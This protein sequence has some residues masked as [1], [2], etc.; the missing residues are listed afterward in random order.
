ML[1]DD[2]ALTIDTALFAARWSHIQSDYLLPNGIVA[3]QN[4]G[5]GDNFGLKATLHWRP[6]GP[7][8]LDGDVLLQHARLTHAKVDVDED[9]R[10]PVVPDVRLR[11]VLGRTFS[12]GAWTGVLS[13]ELGYTGPSR[14]SFEEELDRKMEGYAT[15]AIA[16][17]LTRPGWSLLA[18]LD[19]ATNSRADTFAYGNP[20]SVREADQHT[21]LPPRSLTLSLTHLFDR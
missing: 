11:A 15:L 8:T 17:G 14:L 18:R 2:S 7:W 6:V 3:T 9:P 21:P 10:L 19:N 4:V 1:L 16:F 20:F 12:L 5:D 13:G